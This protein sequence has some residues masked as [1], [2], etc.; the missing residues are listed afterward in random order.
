MAIRKIVNIDEEKCNG[1]GLCIPNCAEGAL[2]IVDGKAKLVSDVYCDGLGACLG[3]CPQDAISVVERDAD[4]FDETAVE[5]YMNS[6]K[7][8][9]GCGCS[10]G[11]HNNHG[12]Q[13]QGGCP[14]S[15]MRQFEKT[16]SHA[17]AVKVESQLRQWPVQ[18]MLV[19]PNAPYFRNSD[20]LVTADCVPIAYGNYHGDFLKGKSVV[21]GCPKLDDS[22]FYAKKLE[23]IIRVSELKSI[24]VLRMQVPCCGGMAYAAKAARDNSGVDMAIKV[25][26]IG[27]EGEILKQ[28]WI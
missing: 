23:E 14:G 11:E 1:C 9:E 28:E 7:K 12:H 21:M 27:I 3:H 10:N 8:K 13:H 15:A 18:L 22:D 2:K 19:P 4:E 25:V 6:S 24:T 26:T 5:E 20:L 16:E 17:D